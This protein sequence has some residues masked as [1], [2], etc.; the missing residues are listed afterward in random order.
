MG[1]S[2]DILVVCEDD[3]QRAF[4]R[5]C[6]KSLGVADLKWHW[7]DYTA[8]NVRAKHGNRAEVIE[9]LVNNEYDEWQRRN[10]VRKVLLIAVVDADDD[11]IEVARRLLKVPQCAISGRLFVSLIP[12]RN[13][14]TWVELAESGSQSEPNEADDYKTTSNKSDSR[15]RDAAK[16]L[17]SLFL[18]SLTTPDFKNHV[19]DNPVWQ[20]FSMQ[21]RSLR[22]A[23]MAGPWLDK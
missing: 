2:K 22:S 5:Q 18:R 20:T 21:I 17:M 19:A 10:A 16:A 6:I 1:C 14:Q 13:M 9:R 23:L 11:D 3:A 15:A 7:H 12:K 8:S 4:V